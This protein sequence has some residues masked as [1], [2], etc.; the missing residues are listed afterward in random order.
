MFC[1][2]K[3]RVG[4]W[5]K[6]VLTAEGDRGNGSKQG[7]GN[8]E[9]KKKKTSSCLSNILP[10]HADFFL[11]QMQQTLKILLSSLLHYGKPGRKHFRHEAT[12]GIS[13][14]PRAKLAWQNGTPTSQK[15]PSTER[16]ERR[17]DS[18]GKV[19]LMNKPTSSSSFCSLKPPPSLRC[20]TARSTVLCH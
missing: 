3:Q 9:K 17:R 10:F 12:F 4:L 14:F 18:E 5:K 8:G 20:Y 19:K 7:S 11:P 15:T 13:G 6:P 1:L 2:N 16:G